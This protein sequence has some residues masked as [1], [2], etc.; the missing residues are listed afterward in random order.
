MKTSIFDPTRPLRFVRYGRMSTDM[1]NS[2]SPDQQFDTI[3]A[4]LARTGY[5]WIHV[6]DYRDDGKSGRLVKQ[7]PQFQQ[8]LRDVQTQVLGIDAILLDTYERLGRMADLDTLRRELVNR[9]GVVV[10]TAD[11]QFTDPTSCAGMA[12]GA[13]ESIRATSVGRIQAHNVRRGK[14]DSVKRDRWPG[15]VPPIGYKLKSVMK[16]GDGPAEIDYKILVPDEKAR[17][18][19]ALYFR[20][21]DDFGWGTLRIA[22]HHNSDPDL[23]ARFGKVSASRVGFILD[24]PIYVGTFRFLNSTCDIVDDRRVRRKNP[25]DEVHFEPNFCE[26]LVDSERWQRVQKLRRSRGK[27]MRDIR[28]QQRHP[29]G[30]QL[31]ATSPGITLKYPLTGL[32]MCGSCGAAMRPAKSGA[33]SKDSPSYYYYVCPAAKDR[34]CDNKIYLPGNLLLDEV[35][36][37]FRQRYFSTVPGESIPGWLERA[38][39]ELRRV[40]KSRQEDVPDHDDRMDQ[41]DKLDEQVAGWV[42][43]LGDRDLK[44]AVRHI[45]QEKVDEATQE[46]N[47]LKAELDQLAAAEHSVAQLLN[48]GE[49]ARKLETLDRELRC[50]NPTRVHVAL[51]EHVQAISV[52]SDRTVELQTNQLALLGPDA[53]VLA[54][55]FVEAVHD[56]DSAGA[57]PSPGV[58]LRRRAE[59]RVESDVIGHSAIDRVVACHSANAPIP[60]RWIATDNL[61]IEKPRPWYQEMAAEV[62]AMRA[63]PTTFAKLAKHFRKSVP[64]IRKAIRYA[65]SRDPSLQ[66]LPN[67]L[68]A[69]NEA[70]LHAAEIARLKREGATTSELAERFKKSDTWIRRALE[71]A[72]EAERESMPE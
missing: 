32:V 67:K 13:V 23:V 65:Q 33:K 25:D 46:R 22:K 8:M 71:H 2:R 15:G 57:T 49:V 64:T 7:R 51:A 34:R 41:I 61:V 39:A 43:S 38:A 5:P 27:T 6:R 9:H 29:N 70:K 40:W 44:A 19:P 4:T 66:S 62:V 69:P 36:S 18:L 42:T 28:S 21:A 60:R 16:P 11:S 72:Q 17:D 3:D 68:P 14:L 26:P 50:S 31:V 54:A 24:N 47:R 1:Q 12:L 35:I 10:L 58:P 55:E 37:K 63:L 59:R 45:V 53:R 20:L 56:D 52:R 48:E 30:K